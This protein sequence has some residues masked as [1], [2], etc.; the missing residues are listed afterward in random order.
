MTE[1]N[2]N[3]DLSKQMRV[4]SIKKKIGNISEGAKSS[5]VFTIA[6]LFT[7]GLS[8]I[9]VPIFTRLMSTSD[10][11]VVNIYNS[12]F[13][14]IGTVACLAL[15]SGGFMVALKEYKSERDS[16]VS[17]V[18]ALTSIMSV[19]L[20]IIF[21][22]APTFWSKLLD[23][24]ISLCIM[25]LIGLFV[26]PATNFWL[27]RQ[28][29]E[30]KYKSGG[31]V[32]VLSALLATFVSLFAVVC[33]SKN[34]AASL[35]AVRLVSSNVITYGV[36]FIIWLSIFFRGKTLY[37]G[38]YWS[39]SLKLSV[40]L[41]G[42]AL[43]TQV[44]NVS[45]RTMIGHMVGNSS[46]GI[47]GTLY[48]VSSLSLIVW[49]AINS[50]F[51][52]YLFENIEKR[53][54]EKRIKQISTNLMLVYSLVAISM[55]LIAPEIVRVLA[56]AEYYEAIYIMP[57]I[58]AGVFLTSMSNIYSNVLIYH[59]KTTSVMIAS[60]I[61]AF[62]NVVLNYF[63]I[64]IYGYMAAAYTTLIAYIIL[65]AIQAIVSNRV[66][67]KITH[68]ES[69]VY[70]N[71]KIL[72]LSIFTIICCLISLPLYGNAIIRYTVIVTLCLVCFV[73]RKRLISM[74]KVK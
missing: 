11:G 74:I 26:T 50:S 54:S 49:S 35:G 39:F 13:S 8:I 23:L 71:K 32:T 40:P 2:K 37:R 51:V 7:N 68:S 46:V 64:K 60:S 44:L 6:S 12:W 48:T 65:A 16:Y 30:Y 31:I 15:T 10:I 1:K 53:E 19:I 58:A 4:S 25:L 66:H 36:A 42:N 73:F 27:A 56:T 22:L 59:K 62:V 3:G 18:L 52:P 47:Y 33:A 61:A 55:T 9:T 34:G 70:D 21:C 57:P 28:R 72:G 41:I 45:D 17:S 43:A 5:I 38:N 20:G 67:K 63:G 69:T 29:Y 24:P 14:M